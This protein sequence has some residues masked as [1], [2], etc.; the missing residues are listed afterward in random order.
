MKFFTALSGTTSADNNIIDLIFGIPLGAGYIAAVVLMAL[1]MKLSIWVSYGVIAVSALSSVIS[2]I[3]TS[4]NSTTSANPAML[5]GGILVSI[6]LHSL[7]A[8]YFYAS[9]RVKATLIK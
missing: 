1:Q 7:M 4:Q 8:L 9:K 3:M 6:L 5:I 2:I